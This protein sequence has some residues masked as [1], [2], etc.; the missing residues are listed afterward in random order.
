MREIYVASEFLGKGLGKF[1]LYTAEM[2]LKESGA[3]KSYCL[4][5][6]NAEGFFAA[7]GYAAANEYSEELDCFVWEK[8]S[9]ENK[10][11]HL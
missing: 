11:G 1:L 8:R 7:C 5:D 10:C 2:K 6:E 9:L 4:P 3:D